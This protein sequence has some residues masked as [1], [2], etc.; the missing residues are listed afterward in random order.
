MSRQV[1]LDYLNLLKGD[2]RSVV[3]KLLEDRA[4]KSRLLSDE[5]L[6]LATTWRVALD[7]LLFEE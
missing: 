3:Q 2:N 6:Q 7:Y 4:Q 1:E 5:L